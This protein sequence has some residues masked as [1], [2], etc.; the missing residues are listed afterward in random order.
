MRLF[1]SIFFAFIVLSS[2]GQKDTTRGVD[3]SKYQRVHMNDS[4]WVF[5]LKDFVKQEEDSYY[6]YMSRK[7][8][9]LYPF[10]QHAVDLLKNI[11]SDT[12][13]DF[14]S[15][16]SKKTAKQTQKKLKSD[17]R[18][19]ILDMSEAEGD[20]L[21]KLIHRETGM[22]VYEII[23]K[24]RGPA[25]AKYWQSIS[26]M[27]GADLKQKFDPEHDLAL[28]RVMRDVDKGV[29]SVPKEPTLISKAERKEKNRKRKEMKRNFKKIGR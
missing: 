8:K 4:T 2:F 10:A 3:M 19:T 1:T 28:N 27:G 17:F 16:S 21:V 25:K 29:L 9:T 24:Y 26:R 13:D 11:D 14:I 7:V 12:D 23:K 15:K 22:T 6:N 5:V 20:I 18:Q